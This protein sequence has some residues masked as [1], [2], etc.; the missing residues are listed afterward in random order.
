MTDYQN[1][2]SLHTRNREKLAG[3]IPSGAMAIINSNDVMPRNGD[4]FFPFR[5]QSDLIYLS[6]IRQEA[7]ILLLFPGH[8]KKELREVLFVKDPDPVAERWSGHILTREE[9]KSI[10]GISNVRYLSEFDSYLRRMMTEVEEVILNLNEYPKFSTE[11]PY[12]DLRFARKIREEFPL[13]RY[14][15]LAPS[16]AGLRMVKEEEEIAKIRKALSITTDSFYR[17]LDFVRPGVKEYEIQAEMVHEMLSQGA[18]GPA[19]PPI[20]GSGKNSCVMHHIENRDTCRDGD[21]ILMDF[22]AEYMD[23][24][25]DITRTIPVSGRYSER[26]RTLYDIVERVMLASRKFYVPGQTIEG[27]NREARLLMAEEL[28]NIG[29]LKKSN[30]ASKSDAVKAAQPYMVHGIAHHLGLDVHDSVIPE[31]KLETGM[32][33]TCEPGLYLP[34]E[35]IGIRI[36]NDIMVGEPF[37]DLCEGIPTQA[38][39]IEALILSNKRSK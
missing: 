30:L 3:L 27:I 33:L 39:E 29:I 10:S 36:E 21:L 18:K 35:G 9:A 25:A 15:R 17:V 26:Q 32:V 23:Y 11:V 5:Q 12:R 13:H 16:M 6:G 31:V 24:A 22:G 38:D 37:T 8:P 28:R 19:Y 7:T 1:D 34:E 14:G 2:A 4:L 20:I